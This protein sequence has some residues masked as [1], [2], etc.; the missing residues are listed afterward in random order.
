MKTW[1]VPKEYSFIAENTRTNIVIFGDNDK[2]FCGQ[3]AAYTLAKI[4]HKQEYPVT[5]NIPP[6]PGQ[7]W[8]DYLHENGR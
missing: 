5:V 7:D 1:A 4:L 8:L 3:E 6:L 2:N